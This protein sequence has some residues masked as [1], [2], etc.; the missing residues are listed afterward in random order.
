M[1]DMKRTNFLLVVM[2]LVITACTDGYIDEIK[3]VEPGPDEKAPEVSIGYPSEEVILIPFTDES[4]SV[5]F[6]FEVEDDIEITSISISLNGQQLASYDSFADYRRVAEKH[7]SENLSIG[8][9]TFEVTATD[10]SGKSTTQNF[11]FEISNVYEAKY[12]GEIFYMPFEGDVYFDL[13]GELTATKVGNPGFAAGKSGKAYAGATDAY[14]TLPTEGFA[15]PEFSA[16]FW[17]KV[18]A[19]PDR[20]GIL[21]SGPP[22]P[23]NNNRTSGFR[24]F[25]ENA[26]GKQRI[27]LNV[28]NGSADTWFDGGAAADID[29]GSDWVHIAF[30]ISESQCAVYINGQVV[31]EGAF[32]GIS[33]ANCD[34][35]SIGSGAPNFTGWNHL[36]D[37]S[38]IDELRIFDKALSQAEVQAMME[39]N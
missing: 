39:G 22:D 25:R 19:D 24:L 30:T 31:K 15:N 38:L 10:L 32:T 6:E 4:T 26:G 27:K 17:Y 20:A 12:D 7:L 35:L 21:V 23:T 33:W 11:D 9:Y 36:S 2:P 14:L 18:N 16:A 37:R 1:I 5:N 34:V 13:L 28:G 3:Q 8:D 29:P